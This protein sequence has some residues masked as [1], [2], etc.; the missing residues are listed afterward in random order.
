MNERVI[1]LVS[2]MAS[3]AECYLGASF[4][5]LGILYV[6]SA[7][8]QGAPDWTVEILD[9]QV[10]PEAEISHRL[11]SGLVGFHI[12]HANY[13]SS[14]R[15]ARTAKQRGAVVVLGGPHATSSSEAILRRHRFVDHVVI[16]DGIES[17]PRLLAGAP[18]EGLPNVVTR[19]AYGDVIC[20]NRRLG[21]A[22]IP[23]EYG[24]DCFPQP[25]F[26]LV[27]LEVYWRAFSERFGQM[28]HRGM[29]FLSHKGCAQTNGRRCIFCSIP[30]RKN[31]RLAPARLWAMVG[32]MVAMYGADFLWDIG[33]DFTGDATWLCD[34]AREMPR[35]CKHV[36]WFVYTRPD[37][38]ARPGVLSLLR[39]M[40]VRMIYVGFET[41]SEVIAGRDAKGRWVRERRELL[42]RLADAGLHV[43]AS[44][45]LGM[46]GET[47]AT[48]EETVIFCT[49]LRNALKEKLVAVNANPL[50]P[51][52]GSA[53]Y[54]VLMDLFPEY[55]NIDWVQQY[56][57]V[58]RW[59]GIACSLPW[60]P[61]G[62]VER[63]LEYCR[64]M[65]VMGAIQNVVF[66]PRKTL[67]KELDQHGARGQ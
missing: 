47:Q 25:R 53:A 13:L 42:C 62:K 1:Q 16:G 24:M 22:L 39:Q 35:D 48:L 11:K 31:S 65:R 34:V 9:G 29:P 14:L 57:L 37:G 5:P 41:G 10:L 64:R 23:T 30:E 36:A 17:M 43:C 46:K 66:D 12:T 51:Y 60:R 45:V 56:E 44:F 27:A 59:L 21:N 8:L 49:E 55:R 19:S 2:L 52:P 58:N 63:V 67:P 50:I 40:N 38:L 28:G 20:G 4:P 15:L 26:D 33:D 3:N 32:R 61:A 6:G 18:A 54:N 7:I